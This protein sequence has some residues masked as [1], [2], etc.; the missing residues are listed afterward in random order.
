MF[1]VILFSAPVLVGL[2]AGVWSTRRA[3]P[4]RL[5]ALSVALGLAWAAYMGITAEAQY[6]IENVFFALLPAL[7]A[8][9]SCGSATPLG[10]SA[11]GACKPRSLQAFMPRREKFRAATPMRAVPTE[12]E[13]P[14]MDAGIPDTSAKLGARQ[15]PTGR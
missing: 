5:A 4:W 3:I 1:F 14:S 10:E 2:V 13:S 7:P 12:R 8:R 11:A 6:R 9:P 15:H